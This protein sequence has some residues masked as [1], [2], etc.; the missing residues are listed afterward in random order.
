MREPNQKRNQTVMEVNMPF[1][2]PTNQSRFKLYDRSLTYTQE[3]DTWGKGDDQELKIQTLDSGCGCYLTIETERWAL[4]IN[5]ID[6]FCQL[7]KD[8]LEGLE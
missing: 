6:A 4:D 2:R 3:Q 1:D 8:A 7:L 5:E